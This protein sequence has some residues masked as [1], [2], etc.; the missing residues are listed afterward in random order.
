MKNIYK[1]VISIAYITQLL[2]LNADHVITFFIEKYPYSTTPKEHASLIKKLIKPGKIAKNH[3]HYL[4][5]DRGMGGIFCSYAGYITTSNKVGQIIFPLKQDTPKFSLI[6]TNNITPMLMAGNT[7]HHWNIAH[8]APLDL[9]TIHQKQDDETYLTYWNVKKQDSP[10][11]NNII[12]AS[13]IIIFAKPKN[14]FV[15]EGI[16]LAIEGPNYILPPIY[17]KKGLNISNNALFVLSGRQF[18][19]GNIN[20]MQYEDYAHQLHK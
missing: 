14:I 18:F 4:T 10:P 6:I 8:N 19:N 20:T 3:L 11:Q 15:P 17:A 9:Y 16:T 12:P 13:A 5:R 1:I 7:I 2:Q